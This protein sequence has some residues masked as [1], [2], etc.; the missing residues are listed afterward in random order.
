MLY[1]S[2]S[3]VVC[4]DVRVWLYQSVWCCVSLCLVLYQSLSGVVGD[5][6]RVRLYQSLSVVVSVFVWC[7]R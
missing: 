4:D 6:V 1:Q 7:C 5:G 2:L 3:G